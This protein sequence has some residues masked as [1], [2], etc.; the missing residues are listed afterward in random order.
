ARALARR[1]FWR[2]KALI[3]VLGAPFILPVIVA[4]FGLLAVFG[5]AG[6]LNSGLAYLGLPT[7]SIYGF[8]GVV[9]AHVFFNLPLATRLLLQGW[10]AIPAERFRL[11][12]S[13]NLPVW[14]Y[15]EW[16]ML[17]N[18]VPG[19]ALVIF[20]ICLTS[21]AVALTLG[22][23]PKSTTLELAIY[24]ALR[25]EFDLG[26]AA[27]LAGL[28]FFI[29]AIALFL[30]RSI[31]LPDALSGGFD[32]PVQRWD[33][34][35][36]RW[37]DAVVITAGALFLIIPLAMVL[38]RGLPSLAEM[39]A[40]V[41]GAA[42]R[43]VFIA[44]CSA[45]LCLSLALAM[46]FQRNTLTALSGALPLA[47]SSLVTGTGLFILVFQFISPGAV[48]L[49]IV[50]VVNAVVALPFAHRIIAPAME[51]AEIQYGKLA[52]ALGLSGWARLR[53]VLLPRLRGPLGFAAGLVA[54]MSMG[55]LGVIALFASE[56][57][58]TLPLLMARLIG[59]YK[60]QA[61]A[62]VGLVLVVLSF[63]LF[64]IFDR[65]GRSHRVGA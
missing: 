53:I 60:M 49:P 45:A 48:T 41:W 35:L 52:S 37:V 9:L 61:A 27:L 38:L 23:G 14:R 44:L 51:Q 59:A 64:W 10:A 50:I 15:L 22:G 46:S 55:D 17:R 11:A 63:G 26:K 1:A 36:S 8:H 62:G 29:C 54:A 2:R 57:Q 3:S 18:A 21:F 20:L 5:R 56:N 19:A 43:S 39:P 30:S 65:G 31:T 24:Q 25:F 33:R 16:P 6:L 58:A 42:L 40:S 47:A 32:R 12:A 28:Q 13:L 4:V 34:G 7:V